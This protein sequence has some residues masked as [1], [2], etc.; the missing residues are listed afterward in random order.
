MLY[1]KS[2]HDLFCNSA[3]SN[4]NRSQEQGRP[5]HKWHTR[6]AHAPSVTTTVLLQAQASMIQMI[7]KIKTQKK[8]LLASLVQVPVRWG[9]LLGLYVV[10]GVASALRLDQ[11]S[12][13]CSHQ[14]SVGGDSIASDEKRRQSVGSTDDSRAPSPQQRRPQGSAR[15]RNKKDRPLSTSSS[16]SSKSSSRSSS[17]SNNHQPSVRRVTARRDL[18]AASGNHTSLV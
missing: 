6:T 10:D 9:L 7:S 3:V 2:N 12:R 11:D 15:L 4:I 14:R 17:V 18:T 5:S 16:S 13:I 8:G 1:D